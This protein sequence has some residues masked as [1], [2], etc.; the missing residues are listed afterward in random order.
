MQVC[1]KFFLKI[2]VFKTENIMGVFTSGYTNCIKKLNTYVE[3]SVENVRKYAKNTVNNVE[4][5]VEYVK[6]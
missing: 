6:K 5:S 3:N 2:D 4:N 1:S